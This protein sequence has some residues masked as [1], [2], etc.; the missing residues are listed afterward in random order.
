MNDSLG[1]IVGDHL[2]VAIARRLESG[3]RSGDTFARLGTD[4]TI[5][6]LGGDEFTVLIEDIKDVS[7]AVRVA[8]RI[9]ANLLA[10]VHDRRP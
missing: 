9:Q 6:R 3:L 5:A 4:P 8:E 7:D 1:H 10:A 2:L